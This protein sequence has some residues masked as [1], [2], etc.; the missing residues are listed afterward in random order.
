LSTFLDL[1][2]GWWVYMQY[3]VLIESQSDRRFV[4]SVLGIPNCV[5]EGTS[6]EEAITKAK[7]ALT[8]IMAHGEWVTIEV[9]PPTKNQESDPWL[10]HFGIFA[11]DP[12]FEDFMNEV[13][14]YR[15]QVDDEAKG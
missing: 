2:V 6:K 7:M 10:K 1:A 4:A 12:T 8:E 9:E 15:Q 13:E 14:T 3:Q 11:N 5:A